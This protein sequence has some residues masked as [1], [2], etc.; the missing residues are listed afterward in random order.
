MGSI[1]ATA[2]REVVKLLSSALFF[3][4]TPIRSSST[5]AAARPRISH[6]SLWPSGDGGDGGDGF[7]RSFSISGSV[8]QNDQQLTKDCGGGDAGEKLR[9]PRKNCR[10]SFRRREAIYFRFLTAYRCGGPKMTGEF[11]PAPPQKAKRSRRG[12]E[13]PAFFKILNFNVN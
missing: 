10:P 8:S 9:C 13:A 3:Q 2:L 11:S 6:Q 1:G 12:T 5:T 7:A 4:K